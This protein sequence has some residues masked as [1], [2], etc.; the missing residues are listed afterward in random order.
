MSDPSGPSRAWAGLTLVATMIRSGGAGLGVGALIGL[1]VPLA[2]TG[3]FSELVAGFAV[4][5]ARFRNI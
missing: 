4:V 1:P 3:F 2:L 5:Y